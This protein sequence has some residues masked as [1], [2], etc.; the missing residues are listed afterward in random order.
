MLEKGANF[1]LITLSSLYSIVNLQEW[2]FYLA[3]NIQ[4]YSAVKKAMNHLFQ[5]KE[6]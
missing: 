4:Y 1:R 6:S 2:T 5:P 3:K